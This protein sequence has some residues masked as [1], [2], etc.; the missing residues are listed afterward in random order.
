MR[1]ASF[2]SSLQFHRR[3]LHLIDLI[4]GQQPHAINQCQVRHTSKF[5]NSRSREPGCGPVNPAQA[6][7]IGW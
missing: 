2:A 1:D 6:D 5:I 7:T 4:R 3:I